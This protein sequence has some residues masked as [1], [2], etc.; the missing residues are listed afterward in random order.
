MVRM[1]TAKTTKAEN[2]SLWGTGTARREL[3]FDEDL[4]E[5]IIYLLENYDAKEFV[6]VGSGTDS[7]IRELAELIKKIVGYEGEIVLDTSKPDGMPRKLLDVSKIEASGWK[8]KI[9]LEEGLKRSYVSYLKKLA[10]G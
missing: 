10:N 3:L 2:I 8:H 4:A 9:S 1:H 6:N 5:A 7:T